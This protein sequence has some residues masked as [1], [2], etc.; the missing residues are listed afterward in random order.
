MQRCAAHVASKTDIEETFN[1]GRKAVQIA[2]AGE[3]DKMV[4]YARKEGDT[5]E[6]EYTVV[7]LELAANTEKKVPLE[8]IT[9]NGTNISDEFVKYALP[10]I[11]GETDMIKEDGLPRF[12]RLKKVLVEKK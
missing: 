3:T 8:W 1:A 6:C 5:Y 12:A 9:D 4:C 11:Q 2:V 10:L 7:P